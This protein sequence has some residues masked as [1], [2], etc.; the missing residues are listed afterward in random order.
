MQPNADVIA[1]V[2][3]PLDHAPGI[4]RRPRH[5]TLGR[6]QHAQ[7]RQ[8]PAGRQRRRQ[9]HAQRDPAMPIQAMEQTFE[10][11]GCG[12]FLSFEHGGAMTKDE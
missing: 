8:V 6:I 10:H 3:M 5:P 1:D 9:H 12:G 2:E 7:A 11:A 4:Q